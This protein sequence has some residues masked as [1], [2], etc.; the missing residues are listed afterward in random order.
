V[1]RTPGLLEAA[2]VE[3]VGAQKKR[4][5]TENPTK[6][7]VARKMPKKNRKRRTNLKK[8]Q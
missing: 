3:K 4:K 7:I 6:R 2:R 5:S 8:T 1:R